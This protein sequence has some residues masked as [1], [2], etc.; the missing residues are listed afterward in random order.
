MATSTNCA[1]DPETI[2]LIFCF[3]WGETEFRSA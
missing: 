2:R 3:I 1:P